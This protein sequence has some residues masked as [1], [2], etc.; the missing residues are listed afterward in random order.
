MPLRVATHPNRKSPSTS[1]AHYPP[2]DSAIKEYVDHYRK[3]HFCPVHLGDV[4]HDR[5]KVFRKLGYGS[6]S[7]VWLAKDQ[8]ADGN[9][10]VAVKVHS[11]EDALPTAQPRHHA[12][13]GF[14]LDH[15]VHESVNG[16]HLCTALEP[17]GRCLDSVLEQVRDIA[18]GYERPSEELNKYVPT[19]SLKLAR[20][21]CRQILVGVDS[22]HSQG[23]A[24]RDIQPGNVAFALSY[25][26][27]S[28][29]MDEI[30]LQ[31]NW[32]AD[33]LAQDGDWDAKNLQNTRQDVAWIKRRDGKP[34]SPD[35]IQYVVG[36][37]PIHDHI[38]FNSGAPFRLVLI[39]LGF[40]RTFSDCD[41][42]IVQ[43]SDYR[44]PEA[45]APPSPSRPITY[46]AD[47]FT[48]GLVFWQVV[49][50]RLFVAT[51]HSRHGKDDD[52]YLRDL[53]RRIGPPPDWICPVPWNSHYQ[54]NPD[55]LEPDDLEYGDMRFAA[56]RDRPQDMT[57]DEV[58]LFVDL[59]ER[60]LRWEPAERADT[61]EL[62][63]HG[64]FEKTY[65]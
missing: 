39:D 9:H 7:T 20:E 62:L 29:S 19:W 21:I 23:I 33:Q 46:K 40:S 48:L 24:H 61:N 42:P 31:G 16:S 64:F 4:L 22:L 59:T 28:M 47:I 49:T 32:P 12:N 27:D 2:D 11:A 57:D 30:Q 5:Y 53:A 6:Q 18:L 15:F 36:P 56:R 25:D 43:P 10:Y 34:L 45:I 63:R 13:V 55:E 41:R 52:K 38:I 26:V 60:M 54:E 37:S 65:A 58:E 17:L 50:T 44:S 14:P 35:E 8:E 1:H 51:E 3:G